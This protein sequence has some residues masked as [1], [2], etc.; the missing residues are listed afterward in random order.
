[1]K[2][3]LFAAI[4]LLTAI[5][6]SA[7]AF[8]QRLDIVLEGPWVLHEDHAFQSHTGTVDVLIA[9][10]P[11]GTDHHDP[12]FS[13]GDGFTIPWRNVYCVMFGADCALKRHATS[14]SSDGYATGLPLNVK[15]Q[16]GWKWFK[17]RD[18]EAMYLILPMPDS[19]SNDGIDTV[20]FGKSFGNY[21]AA[22]Q[23][24]IGVVLHYDQNPLPPKSLNLYTCQS[25]SPAVS[26]DD[27]K[28]TSRFP[29]QD[30][31]GT[32]RITMRAPEDDDTCS[33][34][35]RAAYPKMLLMLDKA[36][37]TAGTNTNQ[38]KAYIDLLDYNGSANP[39]CVDCD[40]Q[41]PDQSNCPGMATV[42]PPAFLNV[43]EAL[44]GIVGQLS[45]LKENQ[46]DLLYVKE[47]QNGAN[48]LDG[49]YPR[50]SQ[51]RRIKSF[52]NSSVNG[53]SELLAQLSAQV[54][55][56]STADKSAVEVKS[57]EQTLQQA[58]SRER[59]LI[60]YVQYLLSATSGK[61]CR[62]VQLL[63]R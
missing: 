22:E 8:G 59:K 55:S 13:T 10:A 21:G 47:L 3:R 30:N 6:G 54:D 43:P 17:D 45:G 35:V 41:N 15:T 5:C 34:H 63:I 38:D 20:R 9:M 36:P 16:G 33:P 12:T 44:T 23:H 37:L 40:P 29:S 51:L 27:C 18:P 39:T 25:S 49:H 58:K 26:A 46:Q 62:V 1:M 32:L 2:G 24:S 42:E 48:S 28:D 4:I 11:S 7:P 53:I 61:D 19:Y 56:K 31:T 57:L 50:L 60:F 52:L 14:L